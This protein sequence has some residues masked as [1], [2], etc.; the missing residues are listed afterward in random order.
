MK[1]QLYQILVKTVFYLL[2]CFFIVCCQ[3]DTEK[4]FTVMSGNF[5]QSIIE[6]GELESVNATY[7]T[8]PYLSYQYGY[9]FKIIGL[10][11]HG[12]MILKGDSVAALDPSSLQKFIIEKKELLENEMAAAEK[13]KVE[14]ENS[15][16]D[17]QVQLKNEQAAYELKKIELERM[18]YETEMKKRIKELEFKQASIKLDKVKRNLELKPVIGIY[19]LQ[20]SELRVMQCEA[21]IAN[22]EEA[23]KQLT[24]FSPGDGLFQ[25][26]YNNRTGQDVRIGDEIYLG[27][28]IANIPDISKMKARSYVN[29]TDIQKT[30]L[31]MKVIVR[32]DALP[33]VQ[34]NGVVTYIHKICEQK[35]SEKVFLTEVEIF[36]SD[37][38]LKPGMSVSCEYICHESDDDIFVPNNCLFREQGHTYIFVKRGRNIVKTE[39]ETG[40]SNNY[41]IIIRG[42]VKPGREIIP[43]EK[44]SAS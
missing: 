16:Q 37:Q 8:M 23:L 36:E 24:I 22:A 30:I 14:M 28:M 29:E 3:R 7:I 41:Y 4:S 20:I 38:R 27:S 2:C 44:I 21:E 32:L 9:S 33:D 15:I 40:P 43:F 26:K 10:A 6:T 17:L 35:E 34:F 39:V 25:L 1:G 11:E 13:Q 31:G 12:S 42:D 5:R 18:Q 19:D